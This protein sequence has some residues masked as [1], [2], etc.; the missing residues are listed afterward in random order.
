MV[1]DLLRSGKGDFKA[2][3][4]FAI[5]LIYKLAR[6]RVIRDELSS[7]SSNFLEKILNLELQW[8]RL[9]KSVR[10]VCEA[11]RESYI[12][13]RYD[14]PRVEAMFAH[15]CNLISDA[16]YRSLIKNHSSIEADKNDRLSEIAQEI[17]LLHKKTIRSIAT[18]GI[19]DDLVEL[20]A[21]EFWEENQEKIQGKFLEASKN[22]ALGMIPESTDESRLN[23]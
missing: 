9:P 20:Q 2:D 18:R 6:A 1:A 10:N 14:V 19:F 12:W 22:G 17:E 13:M 4:S 11:E 5:K 15:S 3:V 16:E 7:C 8:P 23:D 21:N